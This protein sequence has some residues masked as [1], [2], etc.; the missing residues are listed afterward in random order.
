MVSCTDWQLSLQAETSE[1]LTEW[2]EALE[3]ALA[4]APSAN[5]MGQNGVLKNDQSDA[6]DAPTEHCKFF[7]STAAFYVYRSTCVNCHISEFYK[8]FY[9]KLE[10]QKRILEIGFAC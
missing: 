1:D 3:E 5:V 6:A 9:V 2:K 10:P 7:I 4:N 8:F